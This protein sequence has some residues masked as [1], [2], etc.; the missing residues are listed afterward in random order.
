MYTLSTFLALFA[1]II[2]MAHGQYY[3]QPERPNTYDRYPNDRY[4]HVPYNPD[5]HFGRYV[6]PPAGDS[7]SI[8]RFS[9]LV[10]R[11]CPR[12]QNDVDYNECRSEVYSDWET[13]RDPMKLCAVDIM[14]R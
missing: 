2:S 13:T 11:M 5:N 6:G 4:P 8:S 14:M 12:A 9:E 3:P 7:L 1:S 10:N